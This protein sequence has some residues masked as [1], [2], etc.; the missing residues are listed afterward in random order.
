[1]SAHDKTL[2]RKRIKPLR[3]KDDENYGLSALVGAACDRWLA[4]KHVPSTY[5]WLNLE[6]SRERVDVGR[7]L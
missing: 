1:M 2:I 4:A 3:P 5:R 6:R 7:K